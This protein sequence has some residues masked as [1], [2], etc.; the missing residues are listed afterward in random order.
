[1]ASNWRVDELP[2]SW[3]SRPHGPDAPP[4]PLFRHSSRWAV[5]DVPRAYIHP[6][7]PQLSFQ[8]CTPFPFPTPPLSIEWEKIETTES[9]TNRRAPQ[10]GAGGL[11]EV[12]G[13]DPAGLP[14]RGRGGGRRRG[15]PE[16]PPLRRKVIRSGRCGSGDTIDACSFTSSKGGRVSSG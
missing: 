14:G 1:V 11:A 8:L 13:A 5:A 6:P 4:R 3:L 9:G 10:S 15:L 16:H 7:R 2:A 12:G